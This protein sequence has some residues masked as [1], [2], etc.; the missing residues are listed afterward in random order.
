M[1]NSRMPV[2]GHAAVCAHKYIS[3]FD[4][5]SAY[6]DMFVLTCSYCRKPYPQAL[7][8]ITVGPF[9]E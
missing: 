2:Q 4:Y 6:A 8:G 7:T 3:V 5:T 9:C 1:A